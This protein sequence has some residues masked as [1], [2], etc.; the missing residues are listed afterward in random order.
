MYCKD[1]KIIRLRQENKNKLSDSHYILGF[2]NN[3]MTRFST[4]EE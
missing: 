4:F 3:S 2:I 1:R